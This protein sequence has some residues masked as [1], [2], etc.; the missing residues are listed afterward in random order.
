MTELHDAGLSPM[1]LD[2]VPAGYPRS[3]EEWVTVARG[4]KIFVRPIAPVDSKRM[5]HAL[6]FG[7]PETIQ[8]RFL[9]GAPPKGHGAIEY[10]VTLD[11]VWR[12]ALIAMDDEGNSVGVGRYEGAEGHAS[13]EIAI[14][15]DPQ[16]RGRGVGSLLL[17]HLEPHARSVGIERFVA[18][19]QPDN[20][21]VAALLRSIGYEPAPMA[22]GL[23]RVTK[24][25]A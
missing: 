14:V 1:H 25:L 7:D 21:G 8:R 9:T 5:R 15:V 17:T 3:L 6:E 16:W 11:Y 23:V 4:A 10:L 2:D 13:A 24:S 22:E 19:Y 18:L 20:S 12:L